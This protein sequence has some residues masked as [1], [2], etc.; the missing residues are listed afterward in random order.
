M[1]KSRFSHR[2]EY[3]SLCFYLLLLIGVFYSYQYGYASV[4][5]NDPLIFGGE[6][7]PEVKSKAEP[8]RVF[9]PNIETISW[10]PRAQGIS[11]FH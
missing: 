3:S 7:I 4:S 9:M 8:L 11:K 5:E 1:Q 6:A 2:Y 10:S